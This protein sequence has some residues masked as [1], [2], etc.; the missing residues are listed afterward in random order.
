MIAAILYFR[1]VSV[2]SIG[3]S[4]VPGFQ[5]SVFSVIGGK[6]LAFSILFQLRHARMAI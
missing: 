5:I 6:A 3:A 1:S 2:A 4:F